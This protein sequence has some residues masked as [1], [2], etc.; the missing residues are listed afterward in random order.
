MA[1]GGVGEH[2][3]FRAVENGD[4]GRELVE[5]ADMGLHLPRMSRAQGFELGEIVGHAAGAARKRRV[6]HI[7]QPA[8]ARDH[9]MFAPPPDFPALPRPRGR[10]A[11]GRIEQFQFARHRVGGILGVHGAGIGFVDPVEL[12]VGAARPHRMRGL[13]EQAA[14]VLE[15]RQLLGLDLAQPHQLQPVAGDVAHA[16]HHAAADGAALGFE[17]AAAL[18]DQILA[19]ALAALAQQGDIGL[20][21]LS[22]VGGKPRAEAQHAA[23]QRGVE[24]QAHVA[25]DVRLA[26]G[27][28]P[29]DDELRLGGEKGAAAFDLLPQLFDFAGEFGLAPRPALAPGQMQQ[30]GDGREHHEAGAE[31]QANQAAC[32]LEPGEADG[33]RPRPCARDN[34]R[35]GSRKPARKA[36]ARTVAATCLASSLRHGPGVSFPTGR[37]P[38]ESHEFTLWIL[39]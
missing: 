10:L 29:D 35:R 32:V 7:H 17:M 34:Q 31:R 13:V 4:A 28:A 8:H 30:R 33:L 16:Q 14:Q 36:Q 22:L 27:A 21:R 23:R 9:D 3:F 2:Q 5:R 18:A 1:V 25:L 37:R 38:C 39:G 15:L 12:L 11:G 6:D 24:H 19:K 26:A 20:Q